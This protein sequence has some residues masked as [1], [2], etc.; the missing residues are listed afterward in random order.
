MTSIMKFTRGGGS[1]GA[2][3]GTT[4]TASTITGASLSGTTGATN[5]TYTAS[6]TPILID[7]DNALLHLTNDYTLSTNTITFINP[8]FDDQQ[9]TIWS[10]A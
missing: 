10:Q 9:I 5:R 1:S 6:A 7:V 8:I 3:T 2:G 4:L